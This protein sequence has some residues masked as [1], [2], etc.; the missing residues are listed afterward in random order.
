MGSSQS[1]EPVAAPAPKPDAKV[2]IPEAAPVDT[3]IDAAPS[4]SSHFADTLE[5]LNT[6]S[7]IS[8]DDCNQ[9][10]QEAIIIESKAISAGVSN[11]EQFEKWCVADQYCYQWAV[12]K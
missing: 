4:P 10:K 3:A 11:Q 6:Q 2:E 1:T 12:T 5:S 9:L 8:L 7:L